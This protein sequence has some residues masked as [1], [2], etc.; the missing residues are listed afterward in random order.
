MKVK[1]VLA[2]ILAVSA[3]AS[4]FAGCSGGGGSSTA[5]SSAS[6]NGSESSAAS[7]NFNATGYPVVNEPITLTALAFCESDSGN[8]NDMTMMKEIA[9]KTGVTVQFDQIMGD[10][11]TEKKNLVLASGAELPD[12]FFGGGVTDSDILKYGKAGSFIPLNDLIDKYAPNVKKMMEDDPSM[13]VLMPMEDGNIYDLP[14][15]DQFTP[16]N[17]PEMMF[18]N[19]TWLDALG[20]SMP[21]TTDELYTVLKAFKDSDP[22]GNGQADEIPMTYFP[23]AT[24]E[25]DYSL[26]GAFGVVDTSKHIMIK[27]GTALFSNTQ[28]GYK[29]Y[30]EYQNKLYSEGLLD[31]EVFTQDSSQYYAKNQKDVATIGLF[32]AYAPELFCGIER[33]KDYALLPPLKGPNGDQLWNKYSFGFYAGKFLISNSCENPEA[34]IRWV[35]EIYDEEM[36]VRVHWGELGDGVEKKDDGT[37]QLVQDLPGGVSVDSYRFQKAP[38][39]YAPG[40]LLESTYQ[41]ITMADDKINKAEHYKI[42]DPYTVKEWL[43]TVRLPE[44]DQK[45]IATISTDI[46]NQI[47]QNKA[48]WITGETKVADEWDTFKSNLQKMGVEDYVAVYQRAYDKSQG[49]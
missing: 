1:N 15:D 5:G 43:P 16:E 22:N 20:L 25:G 33:S 30:I 4:I 39:F 19:K 21:T 8:F 18:I 9:E 11:W 10:A 7:S 34:A 48:K 32:T 35:D 31:Q 29:D 28:D 17:I 42:Y 40:V 37:Y 2:A 36:S 26:S 46:I 14:F 27:D 44:A 24:Y 23:N 12:I 45:V 38:A 47:K 49:K 41:K 6:G 13:K 3:T